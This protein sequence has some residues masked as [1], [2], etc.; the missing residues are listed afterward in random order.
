ML[1]TFTGA[2]S[3][4]KSTLLDQCAEYYGSDFK[5][6]REITRQISSIAPIN[7]DGTDITQLL[8]LNQHLSNSLL[9]NAILDRCIIDGLIYTE[10][11]HEQSQI[12][13]WVLEYAQQLYSMILP[14]YDLIFYTDPNIPLIDDGVRSVSTEFRSKIVEKFEFIAN[15][16]PKLTL[17]AGSIEQRLK[18]IK[19]KI[20][21][22]A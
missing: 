14:K 3:S 9:T 20:L 4:G 12:S 7:E 15:N 8:V 13:D 19:E 18:T 16:N 1:I 5:Y 11:L 22:Y 6:R 17:L 21:Q 10:Y 2:H